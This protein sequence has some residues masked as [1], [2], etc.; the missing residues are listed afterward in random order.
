MEQDAAFTGAGTIFK[1]QGIQQDR[2]FYNV[3]AG[4]TFLACN[5]AKN[6]WTVKGL[7]DY[8]WNESNYSSHQVSLIA[9]LKF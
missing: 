1:V 2:E 6:S 5:C 3:G 4:V 7:Y 9:S 8:K